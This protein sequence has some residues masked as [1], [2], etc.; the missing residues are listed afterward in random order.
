MDRIVRHYKPNKVTV[1]IR[2]QKYLNVNF[3]NPRLKKFQY[4]QYRYYYGETVLGKKQLLNLK[5]KAH[6]I[7]FWRGI[8][9]DIKEHMRN[10]KLYVIFSFP[11]VALVSKTST[12]Q[13]Y[14]DFTFNTSFLGSSKNYQDKKYVLGGSLLPTVNKTRR[15]HLQLLKCRDITMQIYGILYLNRLLSISL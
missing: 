4:L 8:T 11:H 14:K 7:P 13:F 3:F 10:S 2:H 5:L 12:T 1:S 9:K 15:N 6:L